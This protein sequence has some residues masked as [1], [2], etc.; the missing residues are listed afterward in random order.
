M[1]PSPICEDRYRLEMLIPA[2]A[3]AS[4]P[5]ATASHTTVATGPPPVMALTTSP[6]STGLST[7]IPAEPTERVRKTASFFLCLDAYEAIR[8]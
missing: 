6:A 8:R 1:R 5:I 4:A 3:I 7:P 2:S